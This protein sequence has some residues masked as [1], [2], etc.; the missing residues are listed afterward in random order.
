L[1]EEVRKVQ[2]RRDIHD[3]RRR[4]AV[5]AVAAAAAFILLRLMVPPV[6]GVADNGDFGRVMSVAGI[7][8]L[9]PQESYE[10]R[11]FAY[12]HTRY[13]YG[14]YKAGG[15]V[16]THVLL[17]AL[18]G[19]ISRLL[20]P[21]FYDIRIL[22]ACYAA[23]FLVALAL[24]VRYAPAVSSRRATAALASL[25]ALAIVF[26]FGDEAYVA[27]FQSFF[28]E[29]FALVGML[30]A[31]AAALA[32]ASAERPSG[33][34]L[35]LF[36][37]ASFAVATAK[38]QY[39][40]LGIVFAWLA[41]RLAGLRPDRSWRRKA[42]ASACVLLAGT[43]A[44]VAAAPDRL[45]YTNL[46][47]S[48]FYGVLKDSPDVAG[49]MRELGIPEKYAV[50]AG[51]NYF[52]KG[53]PISQKDPTLRREVLDKLG[54][55]EV[56][57]FYVKHP[58]R[59]VDKMKKAAQAGASIRPYYLGNFEKSANRGAGAISERFSAWSEWKHSRMP[60]SLGWFAG[61]YAVYYAGLA[62]W[63]LL[64]RSRRARLAAETLA[65]VA[66]AGAFAFVVPLIGDGE[67]DLAKHLFMFNVCFDMMVV[68]AF[69]GVCY[70]FFRWMEFRKG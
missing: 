12:A 31:A 52:Q 61:C 8:P 46:Y 65:V 51:T 10:D 63:W 57:L 38:I 68:S 42:A 4:V 45:V 41:W 55:E 9:N 14:D 26:V 47:Q 44:M 19:W 2:L 35:A 59:F 50:L 23:L 6:I 11:Y 25:T 17:V 33:G 3:I 39:A 28:G 40:P 43:F 70:G 60:H 64:S 48:V 66:A 13:A 5:I 67:A 69:V 18:S 29:P 32:L 16:S 27:Y 1:R 54:H 37:C 62:A 20:N 36:A 22:G 58:G 15:Y 24:A 53:T 7:A 49:D 56:A 21:K 30:A 34:L